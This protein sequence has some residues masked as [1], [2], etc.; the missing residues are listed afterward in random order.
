MYTLKV[1][2]GG[3]IKQWSEVADKSVKQADKE[4]EP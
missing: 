1:L 4:D 3:V 2:S